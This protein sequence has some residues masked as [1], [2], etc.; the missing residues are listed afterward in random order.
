MLPVAAQ[1]MKA[2]C[3]LDADLTTCLLQ[4]SLQLTAE[5]CLSVDWDPNA[6]PEHIM[7]I[8]NITLSHTQIS[9]KLSRLVTIK[10]F[11]S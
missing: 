6:G 2:E 10:N 11:L 8:T 1:C 4:H 7:V 5:Q 9:I 3:E